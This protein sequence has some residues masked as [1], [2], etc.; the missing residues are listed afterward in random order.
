MKKLVGALL[1]SVLFLSFEAGA[2]ILLRTAAQESSPKYFE[3]IKKYKKEIHGYCVDILRAMEAVDPELKFVGDQEILPFPRMQNN[4]AVGDLDVFCGLQKNPERDVRFLFLDEPILYLRGKLAV[5]HDDVL[6]P[7]SWKEVESIKGENRV[8]TI[9]GTASADYVKG[10]LGVRVDDSPF[11][12]DQA[13]KML[14]G[15]RG[16]FVFY[17]DLALV[18]SIER[19][20]LGNKVRV[21]PRDFYSEGQFFAIS[22]K[23]ETAKMKRVKE[24]FSKIKNSGKINEILT[25]YQAIRPENLRP[26]EPVTPVTNPI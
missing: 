3:V 8:L 11:T 13:L 2:V 10:A 4:L 7:I 20:K 16:R 1:F 21:L 18:D 17:H 9:K 23:L 26:L 24:A 5:N 19:L 12:I 22:K 14:V 15:K 6:S 25:K